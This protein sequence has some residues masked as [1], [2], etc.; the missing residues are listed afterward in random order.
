MLDAA[1][2]QA[3]ALP[4]QAVAQPR[5]APTLSGSRPV[6]CV[7]ATLPRSERTAHAELHRRG[8]EAYLPLLT[9]RLPNRHWR[10]GPLFVGY[11]FVRMRLDQPWNP[12]RYCPGVFSLLSIDGIPS[13]CPDAAVDALQA[14]EALRATPTPQISQWAPGMPCRLRKGHPMEGADAVVTD[15][16]ATIARIAIMMLGHLRNVSV[17]LDALAPRENA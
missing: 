3:V 2:I 13:I 4:Q 9:V 14:T 17:H 10:T 1:A 12:V 11:L 6:W 8:F 15:V 7:V 5:F 16:G